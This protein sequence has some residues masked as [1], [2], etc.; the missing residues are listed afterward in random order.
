M[1]SPPWNDERTERRC[2][3]PLRAN[4]LP[5]VGGSRQSTGRYKSRFHTHPKD[6]PR[7]QGVERLVDGGERE[8]RASVPGPGKLLDE[9]RI[10]SLS[11]RKPAICVFRFHDAGEQ[12]DA[13][14]QL[15][16]E[17]RQLRRLA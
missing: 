1:R 3:S 2:D 6:V 5:R 16:R 4:C 14:L 11:P 15:R 17:G 7:T 12:G 8:Q 9:D 10:G 13:R